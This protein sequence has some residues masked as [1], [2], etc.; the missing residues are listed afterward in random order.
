MRKKEISRRGAEA[1][2]RRERKKRETSETYISDRI[3]RM[4]FKNICNSTARCAQDAK[5]AKKDIVTA[6]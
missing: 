6:G 2:R 3:Y 5:Y 1:Q 4:R